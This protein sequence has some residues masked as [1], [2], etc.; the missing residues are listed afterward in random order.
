MPRVN[1]PLAVRAGARAAAAGGGFALTE[2][3]VALLVFSLAIGGALLAQ[4]EALRRTS[5]ALTHQRALRLLHDLRQREG[6]PALAAQ[7]GAA[8]IALGAGGDASPLPA[9]LRGWARAAGDHRSGI[10]GARLCLR[11][12]AGQLLLTL[13]WAGPG[14]EA[15]AGC[16]APHRSAS[17]LTSAS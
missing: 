5:D 16:R 8:G 17:L 6:L 7:V 12:E 11:D 10:P 13:V 2:C 4:L 1:G 3:L 14:S 9:A 15:A